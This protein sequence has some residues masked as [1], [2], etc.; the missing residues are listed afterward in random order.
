MILGA[1]ILNLPEHTWLCNHSKTL[2]KDTFWAC[3][4]PAVCGIFVVLLLEGGCRII[5]CMRLYY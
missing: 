4:W 1:T 3:I 5:F 2:A